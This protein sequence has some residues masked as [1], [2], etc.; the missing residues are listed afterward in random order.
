M[1]REAGEDFRLIPAKSVCHPPPRRR[2][3]PG[4]PG[5]V[6][7]TFTAPPALSSAIRTG[8]SISRASRPVASR[9]STADQFTPLTSITFQVNV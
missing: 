2:G 7:P 9:V 6:V 3:Y 5:R 8:R 1:R 4:P